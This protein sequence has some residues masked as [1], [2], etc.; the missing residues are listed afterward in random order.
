MPLVSARAS[1]QTYTWRKDQFAQTWSS[2]QWVCISLSYSPSGSGP[3]L[4]QGSSAEERFLREYPSRNVA[5]ILLPLCVILGDAVLGDVVLVF[6]LK[7][8]N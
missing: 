5:C 1:P 6:I 8:M 7:E 2:F 4:L 3:L